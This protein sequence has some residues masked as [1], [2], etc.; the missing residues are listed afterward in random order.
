MKDH[1]KIKG[2]WILVA[3]TLVSLLFTNV[4]LTPKYGMETTNTK[5]T[6]RSIGTAQNILLDDNPSFTTPTLLPLREPI[7][8][9]PGTY[10]WKTTGMSLVTTFTILSHTA[11]TIEQ[12]ED[13]YEVSNKG[14]VPLDIETKQ[15]GLLTGS[16]VINTKGKLQ[17][18][19]DKETE[20]K[21]V[22]RNE[23]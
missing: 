10:Y 18:Q 21:G 1:H 11:L 14:N 3:L 22:Q 16:F 6:F 2:F 8:L 13:N 19:L 9:E 12:K 5:I 7:P 23:K 20:I 4:P 17:L 15:E